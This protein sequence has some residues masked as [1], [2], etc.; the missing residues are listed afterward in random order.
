MQNVDRNDVS[1]SAGQFRTPDQLTGVVSQRD[2]EWASW[3]KDA[4]QAVA[5]QLSELLA[6]NYPGHGWFR[7][8]LYVDTNAGHGAT[9]W[10]ALNSAFGNKLKGL[11]SGVDQ[12]FS[13]VHW[14]T[15]AKRDDY[16]YLNFWFKPINQPYGLLE[17]VGW[18][19]SVASLEVRLDLQRLRTPPSSVRPNSRN[20]KGDPSGVEVTMGSG[21]AETA[22]KFPYEN[23]C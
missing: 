13:R 1:T 23:L 10:A 4:M 16:R 6:K 15:Y 12:V 19:K 20:Q 17:R 11:F 14:R 22:E 3:E 5:N 21:S 8:Q 9:V 7:I 18:F 2:R